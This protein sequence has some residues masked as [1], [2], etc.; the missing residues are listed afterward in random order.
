MSRSGKFIHCVGSPSFNPHELILDTDRQKQ[1]QH[2]LAKNDLYNASRVLFGLPERDIY[3][4]H[5]MTSVKLAEVQNVVNLGGKNGLHSWYRNEDASPVRTNK[6]ILVLQVWELNH[7]RETHLPRQILRRT[8]PYSVIRL[9]LS[10]RSRTLER[11]PR[12]SLLGSKSP[13]TSTAND[14]YY[15]LWLRN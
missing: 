1:A 11:M 8:F 9:R 7:H 6:A 3:T 5:A 14:G 13:K 10:R 2:I 15:L 12:R 4:Y